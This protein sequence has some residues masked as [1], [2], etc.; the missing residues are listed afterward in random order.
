M[1]V[2]GLFLAIFMLV[3]VQ[4]LGSYSPDTASKKEKTGYYDPVNQGLQKR[5]EFKFGKRYASFKVPDI[6]E[7]ERQELE[8]A[9]QRTCQYLYV[10][11]YK[12]GLNLT[13]S[14]IWDFALDSSNSFTGVTSF[15]DSVGGQSS[16]LNQS[17]V[18]NGNYGR[19]LIRNNT[20]W[21]V[22][23]TYTFNYDFRFL[24]RNN[25]VRDL[26]YSSLKSVCALDQF[27]L[28]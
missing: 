24:D 8:I 6:R 20:D 27:L 25:I 23:G 2:I 22:W 5:Y 13:P 4:Y 11:S 1:V 28:Y 18:S 17:N 14:Q 12:N 21:A 16:V 3:T 15:M 10:Y 9:M 7:Y 19:F 26:S